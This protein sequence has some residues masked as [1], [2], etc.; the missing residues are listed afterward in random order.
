ME[1]W[2]FINIMLKESVLLEA[3]NSPFKSKSS[4]KKII[5]KQNKESEIYLIEIE[6]R[7]S[8]SEN[9]MKKR[10]TI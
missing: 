7:F 1:T 3:T 8:S 5:E 6:K 10:F 4:I 9:Q 2:R